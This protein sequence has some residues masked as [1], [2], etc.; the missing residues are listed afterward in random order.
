MEQ[1]AELCSH[2]S[3]S[4]AISFFFRKKKKQQKNTH[5]TVHVVHVVH[6]VHAADRIL[7]EF[8]SR[9]FDSY[10]CVLILWRVLRVPRVPRGASYLFVGSIFFIQI[11]GVELCEQSGPI[12]PLSTPISFI[13]RKKK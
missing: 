3:L 4:T 13:F 12:S 1:P 9:F 8:V 5:K 11:L 2:P 6:A 7:D 10:F